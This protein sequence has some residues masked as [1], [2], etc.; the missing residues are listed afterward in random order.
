MF[1]L[2]VCLTKD[3]K[4][5]VHHDATLIRLCGKALSIEETNF[6]DL[7]PYLNVIEAFGG[8]KESIQPTIEFPYWK[9]SLVSSPK[10]A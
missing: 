8:G 9:K 6:A 1:E 10:K 4:L 7:P 3:K 2:D 5:V